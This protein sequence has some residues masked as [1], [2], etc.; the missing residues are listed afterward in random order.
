MLDN[1]PANALSMAAMD[2]LLS[3]LDAAREDDGVRVIVVAAA[4]K[5][6][7]AGHDLREMTAH[8]RDPDRGG[9]CQRRL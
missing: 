3:E 1:P 2:A 6:F 5:L 4:G 9:N 8:R 7:S